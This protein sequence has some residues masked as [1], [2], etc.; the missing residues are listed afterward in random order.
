[1]VAAARIRVLVVDDSPMFRQTLRTLLAPYGDIEL[2]G[3]ATH[4]NE[5]LECVQ[6]LQPS[7]VLMDIHLRRVMDGI[8]AT[9][10]VHSQC[11]DV[12]IIGLSLDTREYI[13][14]AMRYAGAVEVLTKDETNGDKLCSAIRRAAGKPPD[15]PRVE[16]A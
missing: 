15:R 16:P 6:R 14:T 4:A 1:M 13:I 12:A 9:R 3:E 7:V 5:A 2:V 10:L 8:A 11:P